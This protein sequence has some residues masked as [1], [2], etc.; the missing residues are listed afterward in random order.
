MKR[1]GKERKKERKKE[2]KTIHGC[3][4]IILYN[5]LLLLL[6]YGSMSEFNC[7]II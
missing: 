7:S 6:L 1:K 4:Y 3:T 5:K 2:K